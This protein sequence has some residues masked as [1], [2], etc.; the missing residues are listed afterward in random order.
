MEE[1]KETVV[2]K[3]TILVGIPG[4]GKSMVARN[5]ASKFEGALTL[6]T[7]DFWTMTT[8][9]YEFDITRLQEAH[10]WNFKS[11]LSALK[12]ASEYAH[13]FNLTGS[14]QR[15]TPIV[16]DNTNTTIAEIAP[17]YAAAQAWGCHVR[18]LAVLAPWDIAAS[19]CTHNVPAAKVYQMSLRL[20]ETLRTLPSWWKLDVHR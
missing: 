6:S 19:R 7:D 3:V 13:T 9:E 2:P 8:G 18:I 14:G 11:Y 17:Y 16:V 20:E 12:R 5:L 1:K 15:P 10:G 4:A